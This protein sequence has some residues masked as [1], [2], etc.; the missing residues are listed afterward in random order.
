M[1][2][3]PLWLDRLPEAIRELEEN[4]EPWIHRPAIESL[5][6]VGRRRAQQLLSRFGSTTSRGEIWRMLDHPFLF[7]SDPVP[8]FPVRK[9]SD[10]IGATTVICRGNYENDTRREV[11]LNPTR[12]GRRSGRGERPSSQA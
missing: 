2:D 6:G 11:L 7:W 10:R 4:N 3:K 9:N 8:D 1:P 12:P 5:L